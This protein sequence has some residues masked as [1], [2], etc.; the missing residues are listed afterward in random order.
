MIFLISTFESIS[1]IFVNSYSLIDNEQPKTRDPKAP[2]GWDSFHT[3]EEIYDWLHE[4]ID[5]NPEVVKP[6]LMGHTWEGRP[7]EGVH[8]NYGKNKANTTIFIE[9]NIHSREWITSAT[10]TWIINQL[11]HSVD[12]EVRFVAEN[13]QWYIFPCVNP[14]GYVYTHTTNRMWRK[15]R[16]RRPGSSCYGIDGNR[17]FKY[18]WM[19]KYSIRLQECLITFSYFN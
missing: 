3:L 5:S 15:T 7:I 4:T 2:F 11:L 13:F 17:N 9:S 8:I 1:K 18:S 10:S 6:A 12:P 19:R 14:D 16:S